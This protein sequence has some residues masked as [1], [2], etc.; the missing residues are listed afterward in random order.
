[1]S[2]RGPFRYP[3]PMTR[4]RRFIQNAGFLGAGLNLFVFIILLL[5]AQSALKRGDYIIVPIILGGLFGPYLIRAQLVEHA[6]ATQQLMNLA[7][8]ALMALILAQFF[9]TI[10][11]PS[12]TGIAIIATLALYIGVYFW[13]LSDRR[14]GR[15]P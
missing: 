7:W 13:L 14:I 6:R 12:W 4:L 9:T 11:L 10:Q 2:N 3:L 8:F 5:L 15:G 1:M